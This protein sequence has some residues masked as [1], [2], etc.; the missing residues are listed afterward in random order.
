MYKRRWEV[1]ILFGCFKSRGF[2]MENIHITNFDKIEKLIFVRALAF[3]WAYR[4][5]DIDIQDDV[6]RWAILEGWV[7]ENLG[8]AYH[9]LLP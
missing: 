7:E 6:I 1:E 5:G 9:V 2:R 3:C 8:N 4:I